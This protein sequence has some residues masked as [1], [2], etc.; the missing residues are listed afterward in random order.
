[1]I[2]EVTGRPVDGPLI[3]ETERRIAH[4]RVSPEGQ[5]GLTAFFEKRPAAWAPK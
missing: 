4:I 3:E 5:E 1:L 2:S